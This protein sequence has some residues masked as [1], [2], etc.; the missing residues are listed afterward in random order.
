LTPL[1]WQHADYARMH[2]QRMTQEVLEQRL[3]FKTQVPS[4]APHRLQLPTDRPRGGAQS[5]AADRVTAQI[6]MNLTGGPIWF[7]SCDNMH[8][9]RKPLNIQRAL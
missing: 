9:P 4:D 6:Y 5:D 2:Y 3:E 7:A 1:D 8:N